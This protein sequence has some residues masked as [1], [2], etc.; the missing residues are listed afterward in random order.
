MFMHEK[1]NDP[2]LLP[3]E[4]VRLTKFI[5]SDRRI[6]MKNVL[7]WNQNIIQPMHSVHY[8]KI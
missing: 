3:S 8:N 4:E 5:T 2:G 1:I 7:I 6:T